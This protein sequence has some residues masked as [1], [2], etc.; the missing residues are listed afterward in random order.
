LHPILINDI[1]KDL[2]IPI[3]DIVDYGIESKFKESL[4]MAVLGYAKIKN[5]KSN[6]PSVTGSSKNIVLGDICEFK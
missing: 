4:L 1:Q 5:I 6:M 3:V 2:D